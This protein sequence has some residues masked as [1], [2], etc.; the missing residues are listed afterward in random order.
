MNQTP[1]FTLG[2]VIEFTPY[3]QFC[4]I[5][6]LL[7]LLFLSQVYQVF[8][9]VFSCKLDCNTLILKNQCKRGCNWT[10]LN[11]RYDTYDQSQ[12]R[13]GALINLRNFEGQNLPQLTVI[14]NIKW[15]QIPVVQFS[16]LSMEVMSL[17]CICMETCLT[18]FQYY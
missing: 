6:P 9:P 3:A 17:S 10:K 8:F 16:D 2:W 7:L 18:E 15:E 14:T 5:P 12:Y 13:H 11:F 1:I 4:P